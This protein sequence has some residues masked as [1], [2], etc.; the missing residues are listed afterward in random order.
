VEAQGRLTELEKN[1]MRIENDNVFLFVLLIVSLIGGS[2]GV[3]LAVWA[4][5]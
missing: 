3:A 1:V 4:L 5:T 2:A